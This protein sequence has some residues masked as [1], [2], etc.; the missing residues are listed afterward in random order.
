[1]MEPI[2]FYL[3]VNFYALEFIRAKMVVHP[4]IYSHAWDKLWDDIQDYSTWFNS[5]LAT[6]FYDHIVKSVQCELRHCKNHSEFYIPNFFGDGWYKNY[7]D[8]MCYA[9]SEF[10]SASI[11]RAGK[12]LFDD[13]NNYWCYEDEVCEY[14]GEA[15]QDISE[16]GLEYG[17][18]SD[19]IFVDHLIDLEHNNEVVLFKPTGLF[20]HTVRF[21][22]AIYYR[23]LKDKR[24]QDDDFIRKY[25]AYLC[26]EV[27][28]FISRYQYLSRDVLIPEIDLVKY[29]SNLDK[30]C[31]K[32]VELLLNYKPI[33]WGNKHVSM[34][35]LLE[36]PLRVRDYD[37][38]EGDWY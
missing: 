3:V 13:N 7:D 17:K 1:M 34:E 9:N 2:L 4:K 23:M 35:D 33:K 29:R 31:E 15:W 14:G 18:V 20:M 10:N 38:E 24:Y 11:L 30:L 37:E 19:T 6:M 21:G 8:S 27:L 16:A 12:W 22:T 5:K 32:S 26:Q 36:S 25:S 28:Q